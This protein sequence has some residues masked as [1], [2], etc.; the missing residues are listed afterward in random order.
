MS[1]ISK[2]TFGG[3]MNRDIYYCHKYCRETLDNGVKGQII[4]L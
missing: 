2:E 1:K 4:T 3:I